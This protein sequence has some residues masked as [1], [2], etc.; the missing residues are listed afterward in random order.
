MSKKYASFWLFL[1]GLGSQT[2]IHIV[3]SIG[4]SEIALFL[5]APIIFFT[6]YK[7]LRADG[8]LPF[9]WLSI[10]TCLGCVFSGFIN[11][12]YHVFL[13]KGLAAPYAV[14]A[15]TVVLHW[16]L[17]KDFSGLRWLLV[18]IFISSI[19]SIFIFQQEVFTVRGGDVLEGE[20]AV[21]AV[22]SNP[23]FWSSKIT[24]A[25]NLPIT[26]WYLSTPYSYSATMPFVS[27]LIKI[28]FSES[29]GRSAA[30]VSWLGGFYILIAGKSPQRMR[31]IGRNFGM[32]VLLMIVLL[33]VGKHVY[34]YAA[35]N[36]Y[37]GEKAREKYFKQSQGSSSMLKLIMG[38][39]LEFFTS[40][41]ACIDK[42]IIGFG[43]K[44]IDEK[45]YYEMMLRK[46]GNPDDYEA[47]ANS[48]LAR[49]RRGITVHAIP[50]H[51]HLGSFWL[52]YGI[53]GL[54]FWLYVLGMFLKYFKKYCFAIPQ[55]YGYCAIAIASFLWDIFFSPFSGRID[56]ALLMTCILF[57]RAVTRGWMQL[58]WAMQEEIARKCR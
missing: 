17:R 1:I 58:P 38:G 10:L 16:M 33:I 43:P 19:I 47:Y 46:Y 6:D 3:G 41:R 5:L 31:R 51:S 12:T 8:F 48:I 24:A 34:I 11:D 56:I 49:A 15:S 14:F 50:A 45:G 23:L 27:G 36:N 21:A 39:R 42:P 37:L 55:W 32:M 25:L 35:S 54:V 7:Q 44:P 4:I 53:I 26:A 57:S 2:H 28:L 29:S 9:V 18:G 13:L 22:T 20:E 30:L 40:I 52:Q